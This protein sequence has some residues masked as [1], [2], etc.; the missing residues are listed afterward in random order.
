MGGRRPKSLS[1]IL[2]GGMGPQQ[3]G[4][5]RAIGR[6]DPESI[7]TNSAKLAAESDKVSD[8]LYYVSK[9]ANFVLKESKSSQDLSYEQREKLA[10]QEWSRIKKEEGLEDDQVITQTVISAVAKA[11]GKGRK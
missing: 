8:I 11:I 5:T 6:S 4:F 1:D 9:L 3:A 10:R 2:G 7:A